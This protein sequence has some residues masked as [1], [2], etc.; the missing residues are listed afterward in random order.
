MPNDEIVTLEVP[1]LTVAAN[2][3]IYLNGKG[4][5]T[6]VKGKHPN[7]DID[8]KLTMVL[9]LKIKRILNQKKPELLLYI[10][11]LC[12]VLEMIII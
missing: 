1:E 6:F 10:T 2:Q 7:D 8:D 12:T 3:D 4:Y 11:D 9:I 5:L